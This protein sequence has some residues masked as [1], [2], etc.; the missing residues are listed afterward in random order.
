M[1]LQVTLAALNE[2]VHFRL[3]AKRPVTWRWMLVLSA[4]D[5]ALIMASITI[6][7]GFDRFIFVAYCPALVLFALVFTSVRLGLAWTTMAA[8]AYSIV[9]LSLGSGIDRDVGDEKVRVQAGGHVCPGVWRLPHHPVR[10]QGDVHDNR[11]E[12]EPQRQLLLLRRL[13]AYGL[14]G[15][16]SPLCR[17]PPFLA[18]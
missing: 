9:S 4:V 8:V 12:A 10:T 11:D 18:E 14:P 5:I 7:S 2:L 16:H 1:F 6:G 15:T 13:D 17:Q 3:L